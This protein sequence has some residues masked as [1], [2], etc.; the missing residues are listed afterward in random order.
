MPAKFERQPKFRNTLVLYTTDIL[1]ISILML[2]INN[3]SM[4]AVVGM[5]RTTSKTRRSFYVIE[6]Q[7]SVH[8]SIQMGKKAAA[9]QIDSY[10]KDNQ[11]RSF[12]KSLSSS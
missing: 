5:R 10:S 7:T 6:V 12:F 8:S 11:R 9:S 3:V 4:V 1:H 2:I